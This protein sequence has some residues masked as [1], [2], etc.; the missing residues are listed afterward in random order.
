MKQSLIIVA[1]ALSGCVTVTDSNVS[2]LGI[3]DLC[4]ARIVALNLGQVD[5]ARQAFDEIQTR[6]GFSAAELSAIQQNQVFVGMS[7]TAGLCAW[8]NGYDTVN[9]TAT[10]GGSSKQ[11]VYS[12]GD[13]AKTRYLYSSGTRITGFQT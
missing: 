9:T 13:Y 3:V 4:T 7:E 10:A 12:G 8:G 2:T 5:R 1:F 11:F 6:G